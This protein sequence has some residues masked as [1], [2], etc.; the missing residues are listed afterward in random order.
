MA[1]EMRPCPG[2]HGKP[3]V[4]LNP[5]RTKDGMCLG[6]RRGGRKLGCKLVEQQF[7]AYELKMETMRFKCM[8][9]EQLHEGFSKRQGHLC[10]IT[11]AIPISRIIGV[12][13]SDFIAF[14]N[15]VE[16]ILMI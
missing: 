8:V 10:G 11:H 14:S 7:A 6:C 5:V 2:K 16:I 15:S 9:R 3:C 1:D 4:E 13:I 12:D